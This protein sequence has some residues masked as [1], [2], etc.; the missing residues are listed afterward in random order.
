MPFAEQIRRET[1]IGTMA[2]GMIV[3]PLQAEAVIS[4]GQADIV[5]LGNAALSDPH[6]PLNAQQT[7]RD[8]C[9][10]APYADWNIQAGWW[11]NNRDN[12]LSQLG[13]RVSAAKPDATERTA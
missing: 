3:D 8:A 9:S 13:A 2:V 6:F 7:L 10:D 4:S 12:K 1:Q 11:L 5:A